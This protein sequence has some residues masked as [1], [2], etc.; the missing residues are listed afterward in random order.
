M[1]SSHSWKHLTSLKPIYPEYH[2]HRLYIIQIPHYLSSFISYVLIC[3]WEHQIVQCPRSRVH[4]TETSPKGFVQNVYCILWTFWDYLMYNQVSRCFKTTDS[5]HSVCTILSDHQYQNIQN[6]RLIIFNQ[7]IFIRP[8]TG[9]NK[10]SNEGS[11]M[12]N[13]N[14]K[15]GYTIIMKYNT[16]SWIIIVKL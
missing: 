16:N 1:S 4:L 3:K 13:I 8:W 9:D 5:D 11:V 7:Y 10:I 12:D 2:Q 6:W 15:T 14:F